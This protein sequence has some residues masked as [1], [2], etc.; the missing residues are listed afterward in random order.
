MSNQQV[1]DTTVALFCKGT[2]LEGDISLLTKVMHLDT[3]ISGIR[4]MEDTLDKVRCYCMANSVP[5]DF[6]V[7]TKQ[8]RALAKNSTTRGMVPV[9]EPLQAKSRTQKK[10]VAD[11]DLPKGST[12]E[13]LY[14]AILKHGG[15]VTA[16]E[17][18]SKLELD[19]SYTNNAMN[20]L[21]ERKLLLKRK[22]KKAEKP[23]RHTKFVFEVAA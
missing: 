5:G 23:N 22:A 7:R 20:N 17:L 1:F 2:I 15:P 21:S 10:A 11:A 4:E 9:T 13:R 8:Y 3:I 14:K 12:L 18:A 19:P 16:S 6:E